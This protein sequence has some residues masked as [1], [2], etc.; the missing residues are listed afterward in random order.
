MRKIIFHDRKKK[1]K[2]VSI[3]SIRIFVIYKLR[4]SCINLE[5][6]YRYYDIYFSKPVS[7]DIK[8][9]KEKIN[10]G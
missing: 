6:P 7:Q 4:T 1:K 10:T 8:Q 5:K 3:I 9:N 2:I